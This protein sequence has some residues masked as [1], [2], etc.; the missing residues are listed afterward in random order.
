MKGAI[1][2]S[3][4]ML[5]RD[6][7]AKPM[8]SGPVSLPEL[9]VAVGPVGELRLVTGPEGSEVSFG[10]CASR[11]VANRTLDFFGGIRG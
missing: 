9:R 2:H 5:V 7:A 10:V 1:L 3:R 11:E 8:R 6:E 4:A